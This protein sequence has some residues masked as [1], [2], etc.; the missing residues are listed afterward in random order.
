MKQEWENKEIIIVDDGSSDKSELIIKKKIYYYEILVIKN[1]S[2]KGTSYS[3]NEIIKKSKGALI[4]FMD[5]DDFS[6]S[7]RIKLQV[8]E[9]IKN[10]FP[11]VKNMACC[12]GIKK[13]YSNGYFKEYMPMG[14]SGA[15]PSGTELTDFLLF[16]EKKKGIIMVS[17]CLHV[18]S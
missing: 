4:C 8:N 17:L 7:K 12:T 5:D 13:Q 1:S 2:N 11:K 6:D 9:F 10:G 18:V 15:L 14:S 16:Y 3:R